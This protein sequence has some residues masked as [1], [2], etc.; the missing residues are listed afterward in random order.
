MRIK[1]PVG[2][3]DGWDAGLELCRHCA[4]QTIQHTAPIARTLLIVAK[5]KD[6]LGKQVTC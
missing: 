2:E 1:T 5:Q 6:C 3:S 4:G